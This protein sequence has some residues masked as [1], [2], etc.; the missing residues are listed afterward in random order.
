MGRV[1]IA[2][3]LAQRGEVAERSEAGEQLGCSG[4]HHGRGSGRIASPRRGEADARS[5]AGE[6]RAVAGCRLCL[7]TACVP[8]GTSQHRTLVHCR[9]CGLVSVPPAHWLTVDDER[10]R[11]AHH[12]N[13]ASN[14]GYLKFLGQVADVVSGLA[15]PGAR[16]LDFGSG[17]NALLTG[18]LRARGFACVAYDPLYGVSPGALASRYDVVVMCEVIEHLRDPRGELLALAGCLGPGGRVVVRT[19]C[20]PSLGELGSWWYARD[21]THINFFAAGTLEV[22]AKLCGLRCQGTGEPDIFVW[23]PAM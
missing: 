6:G 10:A 20:Y 2:P 9:D 8:A 11:Y 1:R 19:Q 23:S 22:A 18:I 7:S 14:E 13:V 15:A 5:A 17:Q 4:S 16:I 3:R 21:A 12:D